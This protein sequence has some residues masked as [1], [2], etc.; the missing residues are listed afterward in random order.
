MALLAL[1]SGLNR[2]RVEIVPRSRL[3][4]MVAWT[5]VILVDERRS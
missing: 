4:A 2:A 3:E 5:R 1:E